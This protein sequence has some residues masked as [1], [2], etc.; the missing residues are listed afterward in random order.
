[1]AIDRWNTLTGTPQARTGPGRRAVTVTPADSDL[2][3]V[4]RAVYVG[5]AGN[6]AVLLA[7]DATPVIFVAVAAGSLF[8]LQCL[9]IRTTSTTASSIVAVY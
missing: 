4:T 1:M 3:E 5:A 6:L 7:D 9:Q 2:T 8:P